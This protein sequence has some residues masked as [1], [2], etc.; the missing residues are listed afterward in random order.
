MS[1]P[2]AIQEPLPRAQDAYGIH[3]KLLGYSLN[4][5][6]EVGSHKARVFRSAL[7][8]TGDHVDHLARQLVDG[9]QR[10]PVSAVRDNPPHGVLC[11][12]LVKVEAVEDQRDRT[13]VVTTSWEYRWPDDAPRL[14]S[15]Y[16]DA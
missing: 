12:V 7:G 9:I 8:I 15:A 5:E 14:V 1:W 2:P 6:H 3:E 11:E 4:T 16:I 13:R 10:T